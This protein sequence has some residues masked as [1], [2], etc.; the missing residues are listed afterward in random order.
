MASGRSYAVDFL[1]L[2]TCH[3]DIGEGEQREQLLTVL[4]QPS[5]AGS[6]VAELAL[7]DPEDMLDGCADR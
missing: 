4:V 7:D 3:E 6:R 5:I 2:S 1:K